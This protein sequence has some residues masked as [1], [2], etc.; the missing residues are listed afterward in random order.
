MKRFWV[1]GLVLV[2]VFSLMLGSVPI[3]FSQKKYNEAPMLAELVKQGKLPPVEQRLPEE[4]MVVEPIEEV[5]RYGGTLRLAMVSP[6][7]WCE[8]S[9]LTM[10]YFIERDPRDYTKFI[11]GLAK[12]WKI[13][14][15]GKTFTLTLRKGLKWS[16][17]QP[18]TADDILFW[19]ED[20]ILNDELTPVK[21]RQWMP[22]G[23]LMKVTKVNEYTVRFDFTVPYYAVVYL[24]SQVAGYGCQG[25]CF[26]PKHALTK[27][28][29]KYN[30]KANDLAKEAKYDH[31]WQLF[32]Y[33]AKPAN[34]DDQQH[35]DIPTMG[36]WIVKEVLPDGV[37]WERNPYYWK[38]DTAGN[39]L[40]YIDRVRGVFFREA[41]NL[42]MLIT[43]G[44]I[45]LLNGWGTGV[46]DYPTIVKNAQQGGYRYWLAKDIWPSAGVFFF[47]QNYKGDTELAKLLRNKK[48]RQALSIAINRKDIIETVG[49]GNGVPYQATCNP[50]CSFYEE[51]WSKAYIEY[52]PQKANKLLDQIG[53][54]KRDSEGYRLLPNGKPL[55]LV[56]EL[57][58]DMAYWVPICELVKQHWAKV[59]IRMLPKVQ[60]R[61]LY[62][63]RLAAGEMQVNLWVLDGF[64]EPCLVAGRA[65]FLRAYWWAPQWYTWWNTGGKSGEEPPA[66]IKKLFDLCDQIPSLPPAQMRNVMKQILR[67]QAEE[68]WMV[69][70]VGFIGKPA[71]AKVDL[72]NVNTKAP[73]DSG[74]VGGSRMIWA[75]QIFWK[76]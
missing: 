68:L 37:V 34:R 69:G 17:G 49:L 31:W 2:L 30:P 8:A 11:P 61:S 24:F 58:N 46:Q 25:Q 18:F 13:S 71:I 74:D 1:I 7:T 16:D 64:T 75:E 48:F 3:S 62:G 55:T 57:T 20:V 9:Q 50:E 70:T 67:R 38:V 26:M 28:H 43:S 52:D 21:P 33:K 32:Q 19:W 47:N 23:K 41:A 22:G 59:G 44:Q 63:Q 65:N 66:D 36:P 14:N 35:P 12:S 54:T 60:E 56:V 73:G 29:I 4:P 15:Q 72:G 6:A 5:G 10:D 39:Q 42:V 53:L 51:S 45:D 27:Y 76:K 40:P